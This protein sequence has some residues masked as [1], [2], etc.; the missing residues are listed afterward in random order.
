MIYLASDHAGYPLKEEIKEF[1]LDNDYELEDLSGEKPDPL[2]DYPDFASLAAR[3]VLETEN[4]G[5]ILICGTGQG[6]CAAA[7]KFPEPL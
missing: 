1:L 5:G 3:G 7:N 2:D 4:S 6:M